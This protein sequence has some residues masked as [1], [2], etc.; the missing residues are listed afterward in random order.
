MTDGS[1]KDPDFWDGLA[2]HVATKVEPV[3][4]QGPRAREPVIAYL[5]DLEAVARRECDSRGV[6]QILASARRVLG[7]RDQIE[8]ANGPFSR[9]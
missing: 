1:S 4:R 2:V 6:I 7:D 3:L 5:R 9:T 8:P